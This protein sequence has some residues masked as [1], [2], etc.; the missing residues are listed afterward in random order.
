MEPL[1]LG[2]EPDWV[3]EQRRKDYYANALQRKDPWTEQDDARLKMLLKEHRYGYAELSKMLQRS[4]GAIQRRCSD[5]GLKERPVRVSPHEG[6]WT[7][8][9][10][11]IL[12]DGIRNGDSYTLIGEQIGKSEKA[13]RGKVYTVYFTESADK[14]RKMMG[15]GPW[16][17][18]APAPTMRQAVHLPG[19]RQTAKDL[20]T[21]LVS[22][23]TYR[24]QTMDGDNPY[25]QRKMCM[26]W[27]D[28]RCLK[29]C[30]NCDECSQF[31]RITPQ[32]C[33]RCGATFYER[34]EQRFCQACRT[35]RK[36]Q[37]QRRWARQKA[38]G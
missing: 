1:A 36:K 27:D 5:L 2:E 18:G 23:L 4:T 10:Y 21:E 37:A 22:L 17:S 9:H 28:V 38:G 20:A 33:A 25:W 3:Q 6:H 16:G 8:E 32:Y 30:D 14:I 15:A 7:D 24:L 29:G 12:A 11:Q 31:Q 35:A 34:R 13:V 26:H 19:H